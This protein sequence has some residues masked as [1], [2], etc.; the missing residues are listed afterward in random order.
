MV[1][2]WFSYNKTQNLIFYLKKKKE[3]YT[4]IVLGTPT[5]VDSKRI[6]IEN[7]NILQVFE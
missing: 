2:F 5:T 6:T 1:K 3:R 4:D 7:K